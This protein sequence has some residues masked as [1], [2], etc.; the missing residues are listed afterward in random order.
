MHLMTKGVEVYQLSS[1][2]AGV[3]SCRNP[4]GC[5]LQVTS[6]ELNTLM[7]SEVDWLDAVVVCGQPDRLLAIHLSGWAGTPWPLSTTP[8]AQPGNRCATCWSTARKPIPAAAAAARGG[9]SDGR[10]PRLAVITVRG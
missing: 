6:A 5:W 3:P 1:E 2:A 4:R 10:G 7:F 9:S 8:G